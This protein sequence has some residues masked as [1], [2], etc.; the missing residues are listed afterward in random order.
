MKPRHRLAS[1]A[2]ELRN[3]AT[4]V[5]RLL[6]QHLRNSQVEGVKF[7]RQQAIG[8]YIVD[9][10]SFSSRLAI[11]LDGGQHAMSRERDLR[12][13]ECLRKNGFAVLRFWNNEVIENIEGV[14]EVIRRQCLGEVS[15]GC[16]LPR[17]PTPSREGRGSETL[18]GVGAEGSSSLDGDGRTNSPSPCGRG[19]GGGGN[20]P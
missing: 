11:E 12:R 8:D 18:D 20:L 19:L 4:D 6:W 2:V 3:N 15:P 9:F 7:R 10:V 16:S 5:E 14:L 17:P 13:D 1:L